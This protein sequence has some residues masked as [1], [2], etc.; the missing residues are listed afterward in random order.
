MNKPNQIEFLYNAIFDVQDL[1]KFIESKAAFIIGILSTYL[2]VLFLTLESII[3]YL[4][5]W[6]FA[7]WSLYGLFISLVFCSIWIILKI[8]IPINKP[9]ECIKISKDHV[10]DI[11]FYLAPNEYNTI[12]FPFFNSY[13]HKLKAEFFSFY[14]SI[15]ALDETLIIKVLT[16]ELFKISY[17]RNIKTDRL[18]VLIFYTLLAALSLILFYVKYQVELSAF[19]VKK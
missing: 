14:N 6:S 7:F 18:R 19:V 11:E 2:A 10:P 16:F 13:N 8:I 9:G 17:I 15:S 5:S 12:L 1:I 3:K 4:P